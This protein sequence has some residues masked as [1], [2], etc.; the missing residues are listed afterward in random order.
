V[1][2]QKGTEHPNEAYMLAPTAFKRKVRCIKDLKA[3]DP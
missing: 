3:N 2:I 1:K